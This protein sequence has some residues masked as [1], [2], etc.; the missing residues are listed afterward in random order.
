M[1][2]NEYVYDNYN[3]KHRLALIKHTEEQKEFKGKTN[4]YGYNIYLHQTQNNSGNISIN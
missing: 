4:C 3:M 1:A 2:H